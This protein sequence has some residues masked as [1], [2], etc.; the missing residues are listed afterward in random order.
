MD[1]GRLMNMHG[2]GA[3]G[4]EALGHEALGHEALGHEALDTLNE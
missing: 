1:M 2:Y 3:L 4:H